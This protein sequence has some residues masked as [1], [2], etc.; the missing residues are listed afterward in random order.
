MLPALFCN[1]SLPLD[2]KHPLDT[3]PYSHPTDAPPPLPI[4]LTL[5]SPLPTPHHHPHDPH[6]LITPQVKYFDPLVGE[7]RGVYAGRME[8]T[9][10]NL[11]DAMGTPAEGPIS[12]P[13]EAPG[14]GDGLTDA[15]NNQGG[16]GSLADR[17][18]TF[19]V[20]NLRR[21]VRGD[22]F[23]GFSA[24]CAPWFLLRGGQRADGVTKVNEAC[25][26]LGF[27][28][29]LL[30]CAGCTRRHPT[31]YVTRVPLSCN[32]CVTRLRHPPRSAVSRAAPAFTRRPMDRSM[33][34][35]VMGGR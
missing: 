31:P 15:L 35:C 25:V 24:V 16:Q 17:L 26:A 12:L 10:Q 30:R 27:K 22:W 7:E 8:C 6:P 5:H 19:L 28:A 9:M 23:L 34:S 33:T 11:A 3:P 29:E 18:D 2:G 21:K 13:A 1:A 32:P 14:G 4:L 20:Y